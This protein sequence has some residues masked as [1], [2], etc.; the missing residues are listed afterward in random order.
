MIGEMFLPC[1]RFATEIAP[2]RRIVRMTP[3][4][5]RQ[6]LLSRVLLA[7]CLTLVRSFT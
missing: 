6:V 4:M 7:T 1:E 2:E 3:H 5:I